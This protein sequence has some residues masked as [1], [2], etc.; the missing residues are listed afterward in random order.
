MK[1]LKTCLAV[2]ALTCA[3]HAAAQDKINIVKVGGNLLTLLGEGDDET[4][5]GFSAALEHQLKDKTSLVLGSNFNF[6]EESVNDGTVSLTARLTVL[7]FEPE[8][9]WY[10]KAAT[11]GF[12]L[13]FAPSV[14]LLKAKISGFVSATASDTQFGVGLKTGYQFGL[15]DALKFQVGAGFGVILPSDDAD[16]TGQLNFNIL[17]GYQ[18]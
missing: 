18:F 14:Y 15:S 2:L 13:G 6:K 5:G 7:T 1:L 10:P 4:Y 8:F 9:R 3:Q 17:V 16:A 11:E 12:Y